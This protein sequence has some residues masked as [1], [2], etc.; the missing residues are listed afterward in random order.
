MDKDPPKGPP[1]GQLIDRYQIKS[2]GAKYTSKMVA[3]GRLAFYA[4]NPRI[5]SHFPNGSQK[6]QAEIQDRLAGMEHVQKL[7]TQIEEDKQ[8]NEPLWCAEV[9][10][11]DSHLFPKYEYIVLEGNSRLAAVKL[12]K[13]NQI[14]LVATVPCNIFNFTD[15][16]DDNRN[17]FIVSLL[18]R[19]HVTGKSNWDPYEVAG[20]IHRRST[21]D[22]VPVKQLVIEIGK[23]AS[24]VRHYLEAFQL[25]LSNKG[26]SKDWSYYYV[27]VNMPKR[28]REDNSELD[29]I[30]LPIRPS[31]FG[32]AQ[33]MRDGLRAILGNQ[34]IKEE[35]LQRKMT[36]RVA[37]ATAKELS[38]TE[39]VLEK[40]KTFQNWMANPEIMKQIKNLQKDS[41]RKK[42]T[43]T[44]LIKISSEVDHLLPTRAKTIPSAIKKA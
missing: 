24:E 9:T 39:Q 41:K 15:F 33:D 11:K 12:G 29:E 44:T 21:V 8:V 36:F 26:K 13:S 23:K 30:I 10:K 4:D 3:V 17:S 27:Y 14:P 25:M 1:K 6:T 5:Y 16:S 38:E 42:E 40:L 31:N 20:Y 34:I 43:E 18:S 37:W 28:H 2:I 32:S 22:A 19:F 35:F 7:R